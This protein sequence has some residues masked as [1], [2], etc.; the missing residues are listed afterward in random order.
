MD[1]YYLDQDICGRAAL[2]SAGDFICQEVYRFAVTK[3]ATEEVTQIKKKYASLLETLQQFESD[4]EQKHIEDISMLALD[5]IVL[6][7]DSSVFEEEMKKSIHDSLYAEYSLVD[8]EYSEKQ[9]E[10][11]RCI[12]R[13]T[14]NTLVAQ[15]SEFQTTINHRYQPRLFVCEQSYEHV[16]NYFLNKHY[17]LE[18][19]EDDKCDEKCSDNDNEYG[20]GK[21][22][23]IISYAKPFQNFK[24]YAKKN[25]L[26]IEYV[27]DEFMV[28]DNA[29]SR[30]PAS[31][32]R[33]A[34]KVENDAELQGLLELE[35]YP[36]KEQYHVFPSIK[37]DVDLS[38]PMS[39]REL[40]QTIAKFR[41][42]ICKAQ[43]DNRYAA[44]LIATTPKELKD[45][46]LRPRLSFTPISE[47]MEI[48]SVGLAEELSLTQVKLFLCGMIVYKARWLAPTPRKAISNLTNDLS[49]CLTQ[50]Y[51]RGF[52]V[53]NID[54]GYKNIQRLLKE[55]I[56]EL[57]RDS[58]R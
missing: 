17:L 8:N 33:L 41:M 56:A 13:D 5:L 16:L 34:I 46:Y 11:K 52:S 3:M 42:A 47:L 7:A 43:D 6:G 49:E 19:V 45:A 12:Y 36:R 4:Y 48:F 1:N 10:D 57:K 2:V 14:Y 50:K 25:I 29:I 37:F 21:K 31:G 53:E 26:N 22:R 18:E 38:Q 9:L 20:A 44:M 15:Y 51:R 27:F 23:K 28:P 39:N 32:E 40:E 54:R 30:T 35:F 58:S 24:P 55:Q